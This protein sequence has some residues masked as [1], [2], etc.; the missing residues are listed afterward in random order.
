M[1]DLTS[2]RREQLIKRLQQELI[3]WIATVTPRGAPVS[4]P[5]WFHWDGEDIVIYSQP[6]SHRVRNLQSNPRVSL[7]LQGVDALGNNVAIIQ[8][9]ARLKPGNQTIPPAYLDKYRKFLQTMNEAQMIAEYSVEIRV[10][11]LRVR[12]E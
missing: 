3:I 8:G 7:N 4:N 11:P 10:K 12:L 9:E 1:L 2:A 5:V 6:G